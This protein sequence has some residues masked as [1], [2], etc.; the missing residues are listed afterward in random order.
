M[1]DTPVSVK[2]LIPNF[3]E[4]LEENFRLAYKAWMNSRPFFKG[5][6][7]EIMK[8]D[9][10]VADFVRIPIEFT[11][12]NFIREVIVSP[13][14][15]VVW[16]S[17]TRANP[18]HEAWPV[19]DPY[20][21]D[22]T[23]LAKNLL[24]LK[25]QGARQDEFRMAL[26][27]GYCGVFSTN[28]SFR[29]LVKMYMYMSILALT[30]EIKA[31][32]EV[33]EGITNLFGTKQLQELFTIALDKY[34]LAN[35][36]PVYN[37]EDTNGFEKVGSLISW[38][39]HTNLALRTHII[40]HRSVIISDNL[41]SIYKTR[42]DNLPLI[43]LHTPV[44]LQ[45]TATKEVWNHVIGTRNCWIAQ[46]SLWQSMVNDYA[47]FIGEERSPLPCDVG[48]KCPYATDNELRLEGKDPNPACPKYILI[49]NK[50]VTPEQRSEIEAYGE[51]RAKWWGEG[52][53][54]LQEESITT[55]IQ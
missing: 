1:I 21:Y 15:H 28:V 7:Y 45:A 39:G 46:A 52:E 41:A 6:L 20:N 38:T 27:I 8:N 44:T 35:F 9:T 11:V 33:C 49:Q 47:T 26:P 23:P 16:S 37:D 5:D 40:R 10:P 48:N 50:R 43:N 12:P 53:F 29:T 55:G 51:S 22:Y 17:T 54:K 31:F 4:F 24:S 34:E 36:L 25:A 42:K 30:T 14:D 13:R 3:T 18:V 19:Y 32:L 2:P